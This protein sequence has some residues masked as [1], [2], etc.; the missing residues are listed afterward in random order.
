MTAEE[1]LL[2]QLKIRNLDLATIALMT[3]RGAKVN[4]KFDDA[5]TERT[6]AADVDWRLDEDAWAK[7]LRSLHGR[8][9]SPANPNELGPDSSFRRFVFFEEPTLPNAPVAAASTTDGVDLYLDE[10]AWAEHCKH[11]HNVDPRSPVFALS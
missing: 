7:H 8:D 11:F 4:Q 1:E 2:R 10:A 3:K 5:L 6:D 9:L